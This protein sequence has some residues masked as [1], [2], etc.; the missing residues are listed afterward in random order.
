MK[1]LLLAALLAV[2]VPS[3]AAPY[4]QHATLTPSSVQGELFVGM[5]KTNAGYCQETILPIFYNNAAPTDPWY[6]PSF[7]PLAVGWNAGGGSVSG[8]AGS[9][10]DVGPQLISLFEQGVG[11][12][13]GGSKASVVSFFN[14][15]ASATA[16]GSLSAGVIGNLTIENQGKMTT[17][18][19]EL[20]AHPIGYFIGPSV[21]FGG[22]GGAAVGVKR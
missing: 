6:K 20:G 17:T 9:V 19:K 7:A 4:F 18:W 8:G 16:C 13:S 5:M 2:A 1:Y 14:C 22:N 11:L 12:V 10:L 21:K 15:S 3:H